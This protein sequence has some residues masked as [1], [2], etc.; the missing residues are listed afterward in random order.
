MAFCK[1]QP[2][3]P[4]SCRWLSLGRCRLQG[5]CGGE[6][7]GGVPR[8]CRAG[9]RP[10]HSYGLHAPTPTPLPHRCRT[11]T[12]VSE[13]LHP[14]LSRG[15]PGRM[16]PPSPLLGSLCNVASRHLCWSCIHTSHPLSELHALSLNGSGATSSRYLGVPVITHLSAAARQQ[17]E[18]S[19]GERGGTQR[20]V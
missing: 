10:R 19:R 20:V 2:P 18:P 6:V 7:M 14:C 11:S 4:V 3:L 8:V 5:T 1:L 13:G 16:C 17:R 9:W 12:Y 15:C